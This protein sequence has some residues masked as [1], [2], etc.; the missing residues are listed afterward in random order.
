MT[1]ETP[2]GRGFRQAVVGDLDELGNG[3]AELA[4]TTLPRLDTLITKMDAARAELGEL[5]AD[6]DADASAFAGMVVTR[7]VVLNL[8]SR[9]GEPDRAISGLVVRHDGPLLEVAD[10]VLLQ[11]GVDPKPVDGRIVLERVEVEFIQVLG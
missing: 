9:A 5:A 2:R 4:S 1:T 8:K 7:R 11:D 3:L 10:A 6:R